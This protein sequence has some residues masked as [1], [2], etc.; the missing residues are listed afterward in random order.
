MAQKS[1]Y[2]LSFP[3]VRCAPRVLSIDLYRL[4]KRP[5]YNVHGDRRKRYTHGGHGT[6]LP[7]HS[8]EESRMKGCSQSTWSSTGWACQIGFFDKEF[9][10]VI[11]DVCPFSIYGR[12]HCTTENCHYHPHTGCTFLSTCSSFWNIDCTDLFS[13]CETK[14]RM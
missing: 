13:K 3:P 6:H 9:R 5:S 4:S 7:V 14:I 12:E 11:D 8:F 2:I 10:S 1:H